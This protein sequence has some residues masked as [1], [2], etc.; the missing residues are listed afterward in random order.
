MIL[1][2]SEAWDLCNAW[3]KVGTP[4]ADRERLLDQ[5]TAL[6]EADA[7]QILFWCGYHIDAGRAG[8]FLAALRRRG[9]A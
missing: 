7:R 4:A 5:L 1:H 3:E 9:L 2:E 8:E 6:P